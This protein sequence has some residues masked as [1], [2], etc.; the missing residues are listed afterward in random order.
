MKFYTKSGKYVLNLE[1]AIEG[2]LAGRVRMILEFGFWTLHFIISKNEG[3]YGAGWATLSDS[4]G[5]L[6]LGSGIYEGIYGAR[7]GILWGAEGYLC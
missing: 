6:K 3:M 7:R 1:S 4:R 5:I 2:G